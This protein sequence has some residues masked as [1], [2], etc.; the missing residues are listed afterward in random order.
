MS[1]SDSLLNKGV[2]DLRAVL[3]ER[4]LPEAEVS[5]YIDEDMGHAL[6]SVETRVSELK[7]TLAVAE[8]GDDKEA[9]KKAQTAVTKAEAKLE[10]LRKAVTPYKATIRTITR[11]AKFDIQ[12]KAIH[13]FPIK[14]DPVTGFDDTANEMERTKY[15]DALV[16]ASHL[17]SIQ[18]PDGAVQTF[19][20]YDDLEKIEGI[21]DTIPESAYR[22]INKAI[23]NLM[24]DGTQFEFAAQ[25]EDFSSES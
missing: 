24:D 17:R 4:Q 16:W 9:I 21:M 22:R 1:N 20:G 2:F 10:E 11:R 6:E 23:D 8:V 13:K 15:I 3:A 14:R 25:S 7:N 19:A 12:S 5:F 18:A